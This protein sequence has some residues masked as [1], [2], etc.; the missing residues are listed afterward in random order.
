MQ[1][2]HVLLG[3]ELLGLLGGGLEV[4]VVNSLGNLNR[5]DVDLGGGGNH[6]LLV[7]TAERHL[8]HLVGSYTSM[9]QSH[10]YQKQ[11]AFQKRAA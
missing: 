8:V 2:Y 1:T 3:E 11:G 10:T 4:S 5:G 9:A 7:H 6:V